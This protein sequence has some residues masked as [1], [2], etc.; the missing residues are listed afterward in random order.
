MYLGFT[1]TDDDTNI[2]AADSMKPTKLK[3]RL[4][5]VIAECAG[6]HTNFYIEN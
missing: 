5:T 4:E 2:L 1:Y 3:M 6:E